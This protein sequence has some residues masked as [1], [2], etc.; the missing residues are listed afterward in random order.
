MKSLNLD[1]F[2]Q[3]ILE[4][5]ENDEWQSKGD[6]KPRL[7]ELQS[8]LKHEKKKAVSIRLSVNDFYELKRKS[9]DNSVSYQNII[10]RVEG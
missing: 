7:A 5:V 9:L 2:E 6:I 10:Q 8:F 1:E 3:D 4:S